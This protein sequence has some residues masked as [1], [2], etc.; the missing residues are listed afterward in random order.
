MARLR[1][2]VFVS[3]SVSRRLTRRPPNGPTQC[4]LMLAAHTK[5]G[6]ASSDGVTAGT[7]RR[8]TERDGGGS[9]GEGKGNGEQRPTMELTSVS[10]VIPLPLSAEGIFQTA[11]HTSRG[12]ISEELFRIKNILRYGAWATRTI[13][14]MGAESRMSQNAFIPMHG[15]N[16][17][18]LRTVQASNAHSGTP[19]TLKLQTSR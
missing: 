3:G 7:V 1:C 8:A 12:V 11:N 19:N 10:R 9:E 4:S 16:N 5:T 18:L 2:A 6:A 14:V 15:D 17:H 13:F